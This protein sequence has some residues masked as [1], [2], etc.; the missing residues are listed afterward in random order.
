MAIENDAGI[1]LLF[2]RQFSSVIGIQEP[3]DFLIGALSTMIFKDFHVHARRIFL[4]QASGELD[5]TVN[6]IVA[7]DKS[8]DEANY[9]DWRSR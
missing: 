9:D 4:A 1:L 8:S 6:I 7:A 5:F 2:G 3:Q